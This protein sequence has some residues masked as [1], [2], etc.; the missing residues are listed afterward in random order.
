MKILITGTKGLAQQ[1]A[2]VYKEHDVTNVSLVTGHDIHKINEWG[3]QFLEYDCIFN[4]AYNGVGQQLVLEYF[5]QHWKFDS[6]KSIVTIGSK[7]VTQ[8]SADITLGN[9]YWPYC[10]HKQTL[11][12]MYDNMWHTA[13]CDLKIINPG[14]F[15]TAM[16][17][18]LDIA[19]FS[20]YDLANRIKDI[21]NDSAL[22]RVD[23]WL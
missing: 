5:Y 8:P 14:A 18:H 9:S 22:K 15:D 6:S 3:H 4:C 10:I 23:L 1:L 21:T 17:A 12:L 2:S 13:C 7:A 20:L 19:K 11:Q 16:V